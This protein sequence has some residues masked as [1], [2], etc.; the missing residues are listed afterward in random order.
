M[1]RSSRLS[2]RAP[3]CNHRYPYK[4]ETEGDFTRAQACKCTH[5]SMHTGSQREKAN[6]KKSRERFESTG[7]KDWSDVV[8]GKECQQPPK[9]GRNEERILP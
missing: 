5:M 4:K 7:L 8:T 1:G 2:E 9:A 3:K 6:I